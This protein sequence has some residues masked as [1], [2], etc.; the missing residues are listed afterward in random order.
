MHICGMEALKLQQGS[1]FWD[2]LCKEASRNFRMFFVCIEIA[3][4]ACDLIPVAP[5]ESG[6]MVQG[7]GLFYF[8][9]YCV[10][11]V[12]SS[13]CLPFLPP[14][15]FFFFGSVYDQATQT[16]A[17]Q[18]LISLLCPKSHPLHVALSFV[19][20]VFFSPSRGLFALIS[21]YLLCLTSFIL[22]RIFCSPQ[23]MNAFS[24]RVQHEETF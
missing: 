16:T 8:S 24:S 4:F 1:V 14:L 9:S 12:S 10:M 13:F 20:V 7:S 19:L 5:M 15:P 18:A 3:K 6:H 11:W 22:L 2:S 17:A 21:L 23:R